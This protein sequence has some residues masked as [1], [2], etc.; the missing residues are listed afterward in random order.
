MGHWVLLAGQKTPFFVVLYH[1]E[2]LLVVALDV[3]DGNFVGGGGLGSVGKE[4]GEGHCPA[5]VG[6]DDDL[7]V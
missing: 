3:E 5:V 1:G 6:A 4:E 7:L 2:F